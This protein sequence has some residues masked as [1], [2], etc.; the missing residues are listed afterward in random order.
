MAFTKLQ[1]LTAMGKLVRAL[2]K[3]G[4]SNLAALG[5]DA[6]PKL[7]DVF[8]NLKATLDSPTYIDA[9]NN[10]INNGLPGNTLTAAQKRL[11]H[12]AALQAMID[13]ELLL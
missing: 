6:K 10:A 8:D 2:K 9:Q 13:G 1:A 4:L 3:S 7:L 5:D 11:I 12:V